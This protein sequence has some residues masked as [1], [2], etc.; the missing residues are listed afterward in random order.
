MQYSIYVL[1]PLKYVLA[2]VMYMRL[3]YQIHKYMR[4]QFLNILMST[5]SNGTSAHVVKNDFTHKTLSFQLLLSFFFA[6]QSR[7]PDAHVHTCLDFTG[8]PV[9][10]SPVAMA[11]IS[12]M[13]SPISTK[14]DFYPKIQ[15]WDSLFLGDFQPTYVYAYIEYTFRPLAHIQS[16]PSI[17]PV[18]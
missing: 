14:I 8:P 1:E 11:T 3:C 4:F 6:I 12:T 17:R 7:S 18:S 5:I 15:R 16:Q 10:W 13:I 9:P 2:V